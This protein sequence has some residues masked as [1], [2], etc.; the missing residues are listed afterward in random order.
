MS[1]NNTIRLRTNVDPT[2]NK[3]ITLK[4]EQDFDVIEVLSLKLKQSDIYRSYNA[5][6]GV[7]VG[8]VQS[9]QVGLPNCKV[10][11]FIPIEDVDLTNPEILSI[12]PFKT[13]RDKN[14]DGKRYNLL[15]KLKKLNPFS[16]FKENNYGIGYKPKTPVGSIPD[17]QE[18]LS[19]DTWIE[20]YEKYYK[21]TTTTNQSGDYMLFGVPVGLQQVHLDCDITDIG[22]FSTSIPVLTQVIGL[23][24]E[25]FNKNGT[26]INKSNDLNNIPTIQSQDVSKNIIPLWGDST[27]TEI[28]ISR[29]DFNIVAKILPSATIFGSGATQGPDSF[30]GDRIIYRVIAGIKNLCIFIGCSSAE[31]GGDSPG[32]AIKF[33]FRLNLSFKGFTIIDTTIG[34]L[35]C[36][37][38]GAVQLR[39]C[40]K[41][42]IANILP[43]FCVDSV[44]FAPC[45]INGGE[46]EQNPIDFLWLGATNSCGNCAEIQKKYGVQQ[47]FTSR[48]YL[49]DCRY[50]PINVNVFG[51]SDKL[52]EN[53]ILNENFDTESD[54]EKYTEKQFARIS[55]IPGTFLLQIPCNTSKVIT[56]EFGNEVLSD[57][58]NIGIPTEF[59][60]YMIFDME[61]GTINTSGSK[62][63]A[64]RVRIKVPQCT[65][66]NDNS[67]IKN[68]YRF[69]AN[70]VYTVSQFMTVTDGDSNGLISTKSGILLDVNTLGKNSADYGVDLQML[71]NDVQVLGVS[72]GAK[73]ATIFK[74]DWLN[75]FLFFYQVAHKRKRGRRTDVKCSVFISDNSTNN[76]PQRS[77]D[78]SQTLGGGETNTK[79][80]LNGDYFPTNFVKIDNDEL[81]DTIIPTNRRGFSI[82]A[83]NSSLMRKTNK[84]YFYKGL[85][86]ENNSLTQ[87]VNRDII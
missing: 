1:K 12:Y 21:L 59:W 70:D 69:T 42:V 9:N 72:D 45:Q 61:G 2:K 71:N 30:W 40:I 47:A 31:L 3:N 52:S 8:R 14:K 73:D 4:I 34:N 55:S 22:K 15:N 33:C 79:Y 58:A 18:L 77:R 13:P 67:W 65:D 38:G 32:V 49:E 28:G 26:K 17:K 20:V 60:G 41:I 29:Q 24:N 76:Y 84:G 27:Q 54:I 82:T 44:R 36:N 10:S 66:Y 7:L 64:D 86:P 68:S 62:I 51:L 50:G 48:L 25:M 87:L 37:G 80:I 74:N 16:G 6:Y 5:D 53:D 39:I 63:V 78:N 57:N 23:G 19:N 81:I 43:L 46:F 56:D 85:Y 83:P 11:I 35:Q 75:G